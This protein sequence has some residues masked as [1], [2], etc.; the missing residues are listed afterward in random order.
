MEKSWKKEELERKSLKDIK[1][2]LRSQG[3]STTGNKQN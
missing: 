3:L 1:N 2:I